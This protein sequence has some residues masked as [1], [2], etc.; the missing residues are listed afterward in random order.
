MTLADLLHLARQLEPD[1]RRELAEILL[2]ESV[3][4]DNGL[5]IKPLP[6]DQI[7]ALGL[8]GGWQEEDIDDPVAWLQQQRQKRRQKTQ[9]S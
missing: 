1:A 2:T 4:R 7:V 8:T 6:S 3:E 5:G 9:W